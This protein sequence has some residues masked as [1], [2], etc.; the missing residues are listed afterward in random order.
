MRNG[1]KSGIA[2]RVFLL[3]A[4]FLA[5]AGILIYKAHTGAWSWGTTACAATATG[6]RRWRL[7]GSR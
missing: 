1:R 2:A 6:G 3:V 4:V 7:S 5:L